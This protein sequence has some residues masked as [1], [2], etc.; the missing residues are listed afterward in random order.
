MEFAENEFE[1]LAINFNGLS[2]DTDVFKAF[3]VLT[4]YP[5][6][7][8]ELP[9]IDRFKFF[10]YLSLLY[11][12]NTPLIRIDDFRKR[13]L[14]AAKIADFPVNEEGFEEPYGDLIYGKIQKANK[15]I[16][17]FCRMQRSTDFSEASV[18]ENIFYSE[19]ENL[20]NCTDP[21]EKKLGMANTETAKKI[22]QGAI[23]SLLAGDENKRLTADLM[24]EIETTQLELTPEDIALKLRSGADPLNGFNPYVEKGRT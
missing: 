11:Q 24:D 10:K 18:Y 20:L 9:G 14:E 21:A 6:F 12:Q 1:G 23:T 4:I 16:I 2:E 5:E 15:Q 19:L 3:P 17:R 8:N 7:K 22:M 13:R